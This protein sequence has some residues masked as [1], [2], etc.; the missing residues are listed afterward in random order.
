M[1]KYRAGYRLY[2]VVVKLLA[3]GADV[4]MVTGFW[5]ESAKIDSPRLGFVRWRS[6]TNGRI[7]TW[8]VA[9]TPPLIPLRKVKI[10]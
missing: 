2:N 8:I 5:R 4:A 7:A 3:Q 10:L 1:T 9:L 6:T